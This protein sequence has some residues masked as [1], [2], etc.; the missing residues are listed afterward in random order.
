MTL[1]R[2]SPGSSVIDVLDHVLHKGIVIDSRACVSRGG[3]DLFSEDAQIVVDFTTHFH[4]R[5]EDRVREERHDSRATTITNRK[6]K[7][8]A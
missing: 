1:N 8:H 4:R 6:A 7:R 3:I 5:A 2:V